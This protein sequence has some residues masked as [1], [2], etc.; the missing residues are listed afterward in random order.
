MV[1]EKLNYNSGKQEK[2]ENNSI[3]ALLLSFTLQLMEGG[4]T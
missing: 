1:E 4:I 3:H 2:Q